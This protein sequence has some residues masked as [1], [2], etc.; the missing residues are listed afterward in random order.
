M[1]FAPITQERVEATLDELGLKHY[2]SESDDMTVT[3]F[4]SAVCFFRF[5][6]DMFNIVARWL[7]TARTEEDKQAL[8]R[9]VNTINRSLPRLRIHPTPWEDDAMLAFV[10]SPFFPSGGAEDE[11]LKRM[12]DFYFS[13]LRYATDALNEELSELRDDIARER[14][15]ESSTETDAS[16]ASAEGA[17]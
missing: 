10:D 8:R 6:G 11:Q 14:T 2:R 5:D 4:P 12:L 3:A 13:M 9:C 15:A 16:D 17:Q 1:A 7:G